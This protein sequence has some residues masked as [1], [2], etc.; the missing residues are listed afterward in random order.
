MPLIGLGCVFS[1]SFIILSRV[2]RSSGYFAM[3]TF[4]PGLLPSGLWSLV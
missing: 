1:V 4:N 3:L 2:V